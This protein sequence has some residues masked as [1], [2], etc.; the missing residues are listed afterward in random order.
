MEYHGATTLRSH[1]RVL[2]LLLSLSSFAQAQ[3]IVPDVF[4]DTTPGRISKEELEQEK[5]S[6]YDFITKYRTSEFVGHTQYVLSALNLSIRANAKYSVEKN[7]TIMFQL[8]TAGN[9]HIHHS[10]VTFPM[11]GSVIFELKDRT[12]KIVSFKS[13]EGET[14]EMAGK[15]GHF[16]VLESERSFDLRKNVQSKYNRADK[17]MGRF[18]AIT[19]FDLFSQDIEFYEIHN[20]VLLRRGSFNGNAAPARRGW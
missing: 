8:A 10:D 19:R 4:V 15:K 12:G 9:H 13:E 18:L 3:D 7:G 16:Y 11:Q 5:A 1:M 20:G 14:F 6:F 17:P 2:L